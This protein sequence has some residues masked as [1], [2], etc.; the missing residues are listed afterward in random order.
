MSQ[1]FPKGENSMSVFVKLLPKAKRRES[2]VFYVA[3][4]DTSDKPHE[5]IK[6]T[7]VRLPASRDSF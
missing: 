6:H 4:A 1:E 7:A 2:E 5:E 3:V